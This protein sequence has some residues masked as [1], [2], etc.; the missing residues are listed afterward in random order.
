VKVSGASTL[1]ISL[2]CCTSSRAATRGIRLLPAEVAVAM[3]YSWVWPSS[4]T[5]GARF[6]GRPCSSS[7]ASTISTLVTPAT[8]AA[9]SAAGRQFSPATSTV[10]SLPSLVA[11]VTALRVAAF[12]V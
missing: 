5:S 12:S 8:L 3:R 4:A 1:M 10:M 7:A 11:A 6:S 2:T 9:A